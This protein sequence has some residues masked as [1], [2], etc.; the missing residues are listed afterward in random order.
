MVQSF[1]RKFCVLCALTILLV[2]CTQQPLSSQHPSAIA[3]S[4]P[5]LATLRQRPLQL[6][7][8]STDQSCPVSSAR[9]IDADS[10]I[11]IGNGPAYAA[12]GLSQPSQQPVLLFT[13][14]QH[15]ANGQSQGWGGAKVRWIV[16]SSYY[17]PLLIRGSQL[18]N[19]HQIRFDEGL[20]SEIAL[21]I[22]Q[23]NSQQWYD[24]PSDTRLQVP[25]CYAY[26]VDGVGFSQIIVFQAVVEKQQPPF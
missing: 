1:M 17:G 7:R 24:R 19:S 6:P 16:R 21:T 11:T 18:D 3:T 15:Y 22:P 20:L 9:Q 4:A 23:G 13:D 14:A 2:A 5:T 26:Q 12:I 25:G 8:I 10:P